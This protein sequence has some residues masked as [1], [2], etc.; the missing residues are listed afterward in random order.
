MVSKSFD[1][2]DFEKSSGRTMYGRI[3]EYSHS[4]G[5]VLFLQKRERIYSSPRMSWGSSRIRFPLVPPLGYRR[6]ASARL[7]AEGKVTFRR[8]CIIEGIA[9]S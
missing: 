6:T 1:Q 3:K 7:F 4:R 9:A 2:K 8:D 5:M